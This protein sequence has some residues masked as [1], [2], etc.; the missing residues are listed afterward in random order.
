MVDI[1]AGCGMTITVLSGSHKKEFSNTL[2]V[3]V[4]AQLSKGFR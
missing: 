3:A 2:E 4:L 1:G